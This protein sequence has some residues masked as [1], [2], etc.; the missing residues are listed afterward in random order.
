MLPPP[1]NE[2]MKSICLFAVY[3]THNWPAKQWHSW[4]PT[5][6][7]LISCSE[8]DG[9]KFFRCK[10]SVN[11]AFSLMGLWMEMFVKTLC[12]CWWL[13]MCYSLIDSDDQH[14]IIINLIHCLI[15]CLIPIV[16]CWRCFTKCVLRLPCELIFSLCQHSDVIFAWG[17]G[18][19]KTTT[20]MTFPLWKYH[21]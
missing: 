7:G 5:W 1:V 16:L 18:R 11:V 12:L 14:I 21:Y 4:L 3:C 10:W 8:S 6:P 20:Y 19:K 15:N 2:Q 9:S 17:P 13:I